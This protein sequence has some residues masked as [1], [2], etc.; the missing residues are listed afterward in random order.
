MRRF[1]TLIALGT[2][3]TWGWLGCEAMDAPAESATG[4]KPM[5]AAR[6]AEVGK[7]RPPESKQPQVAELSLAETEG[8]SA[9]DLRKKGTDAYKAGEL[10]R[11]AAYYLAALDNTER[12]HELHRLLGSVYARQGARKAAYAEYKRYVEVCPKCMYAPTVNKILA[13]YEKLTGGKRSKTPPTRTEAESGDPKTRFLLQIQREDLE[14]ARAI[15][16][17]E[18]DPNGPGRMGG[19][20]LHDLAIAGEADAIT[21]VLEAGGDPTAKDRRG[22]TPVQQ[23]A[24]WGRT[25]AL[26]AFLNHG[27]PADIEDDNGRGLLHMAVQ[28]LGKESL[29][30]VKRLLE[31][32]LKATAR[33]RDGY[34]PLHLART[35][36]IARLLIEHG[37]DVNA[38]ARL[39]KRRR[40]MMVRNNES[41]KK[42]EEAIGGHLQVDVGKY[43]KPRITP[44]LMAARQSG[45]DVIQVL[46]ESGADVNA[47]DYGGQT[48][49]SIVST[50]G[51][52]ALIELLLSHG[53]KSVDE[54]KSGGSALHSAA[55]AG[56]VEAIALLLK[57][58][59]KPD[60]RDKN[61]RTPLH[62]AAEWGRFKA[63]EALIAAGAKVDAASNGGKTPLYVAAG[64]HFEDNSAVIGLLLEHGADPN[65]RDSH[66][67][68]PLWA[69]AHPG[70]VK[71]A[72][73]LLEAGAD[74]NNRN[75]HGRTPLHWAAFTKQ[76]DYARVLLDAG[77]EVDARDEEGRTPLRHIGGRI[78]LET[79][80][81]LLERG[82]DPNLADF[83]RGWTSLHDAAFWGKPDVA[84]LLLDKGADVNARDKQGRTPLALANEKGH[85]AVAE[86]LRDS[87]AEE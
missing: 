12:D 22:R 7:P 82:A 81:L 17:S 53:A 33:D 16:N 21:L 38:K 9:K 79:A 20:W 41:F 18:L 15:L 73:L 66:G 64:R 77:A 30:L 23:A 60:V 14:A 5:T 32:G 37:A 39:D 57:K 87:G 51:D 45:A 65:A 70:N 8:L 75:K 52:K 6:P 35:G 56:K 50:R 71:V 85:Q 49:L 10:D 3:P 80:R 54:G 83:E 76:T 84:D 36:E 55:F 31:R 28:A 69:G 29:T 68:T 47:I 19:T 58:G 46:V 63:V 44:L 59:Y 43:E 61:G 42:M 40:E 78:S 11:A 48:A 26:E 13:D 27:V 25:E 34:T 74:V 24:S 72:R 4:K 67:N 2:L 1:V 86:V 62:E